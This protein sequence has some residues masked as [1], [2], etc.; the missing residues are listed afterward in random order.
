MG[1]FDKDKKFTASQ[2]AESKPEVQKKYIAA[3]FCTNCGN[4][5]SMN[6]DRGDLIVSQACSCCETFSLMPAWAKDRI[7]L[8]LGDYIQN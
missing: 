8:E 6:I 7:T 2:P 3:V 5:E 4:T 1:L